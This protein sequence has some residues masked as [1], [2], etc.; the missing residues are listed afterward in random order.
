[1][2]QHLAKVISQFNG[3]LAPSW[4]FTD[5]HL[6]Q[7]QRALLTDHQMWR[8]SG[9][10][11]GEDVI[12]ISLNLVDYFIRSLVLKKK[13]EKIARSVHACSGDKD[14]TKRLPVTCHL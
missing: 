12:K 13:R 7:Q 4:S 5:W 11:C 14:G 6:L 1:M 3:C 9:F 2:A 8:K 10:Y